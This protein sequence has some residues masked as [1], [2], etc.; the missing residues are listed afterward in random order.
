MIH[1]S[2]NES[3]PGECNQH[4]P[5]DTVGY[6]PESRV[7]HGGKTDGYDGEVVS[8]MRDHRAI[9][10]FEVLERSDRRVLT[11]YE[12]TDTDLYEFAEHSEL[13]GVNG[14]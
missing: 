3:D 13:T 11:K 5:E 14:C 1:A 8:A 12:T 2:Q 6:L 10:D 7:R 9:T 4:R